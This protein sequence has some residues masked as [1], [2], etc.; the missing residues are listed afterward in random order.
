MFSSEPVSVIGCEIRYND[1]AGVVLSGC[2]P[3]HVTDVRFALSDVT[4][5]RFGFVI[6]E[7]AHL[8]A[9]AGPCP[10]IV[11]LGGNNLADNDEQ[12]VIDNCGTFMV[13]AAPA[14]PE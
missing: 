1:N 12:D 5:N 13:S 9:C 3:D 4:L 8:G 14:L 11:D 2:A 10:E 7:T 6:Q